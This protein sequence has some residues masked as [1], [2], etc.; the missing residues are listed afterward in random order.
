[1]RWRRKF[2]RQPRPDTTPVVGA[3][4]R[5]IEGGLEDVVG[6]K[7]CVTLREMLTFNWRADPVRLSALMRAGWCWPA[8]PSGRFTRLE[9]G[10]GFSLFQSQ[11][12]ID[13]CG[14]VIS[15]LWFRNADMALEGANEALHPE[16]RNGATGR[17][18]ERQLRQLGEAETERFTADTAKKTGQSERAAARGERVSCRPKGKQLARM[19]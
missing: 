4:Y 10:E 3:L 17:N 5:P 9:S 14:N 19:C 8:V 18:H 6:C 16:T 15:P 1:M 2:R 11:P 7:F 12:P 13:S